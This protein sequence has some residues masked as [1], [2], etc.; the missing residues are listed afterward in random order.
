MEPRFA[1]YLPMLT[2]GRHCDG[3]LNRLTKRGTGFAVKA[4]PHR[5][6]LQ[7]PFSEYCRHSRPMQYDS[8]AHGG[9]EWPLTSLWCDSFASAANSHFPP[10]RVHGEDKVTNGPN[11]TLTSPFDATARLNQ[12][13]HSLIPRRRA[14][15]TDRQGLRCV[16]ANTHTLH[17]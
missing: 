2:C 14:R 3:A 12:I 15:K 13:G 11:R 4:A 6:S 16:P 5:Y 7:R 1:R 9:I 10:P 8:L 17:G